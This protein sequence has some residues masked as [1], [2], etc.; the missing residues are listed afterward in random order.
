MIIPTASFLIGRAAPWVQVAREASGGTPSLGAMD[1]D[2]GPVALFAAIV[3][4]LE[5]V[6]LRAAAVGSTMTFALGIGIAAK[7]RLVL[8]AVR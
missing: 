2:T 8:A 1:S 5:S 7:A 6:P 4:P 3:A